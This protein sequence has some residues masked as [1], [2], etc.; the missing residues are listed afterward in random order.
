MVSGTGGI[1]ERLAALEGGAFAR[2]EEDN[3]S[4][5]KIARVEVVVFAVGEL[6]APGAIHIHLEDMVESVLGNM[7]LVRLVLL[8]G[9]FGMECAGGEQ[10]PPAVEGE[11]RFHEAADR[12]VAREAA[13]AGFT[14]LEAFEQTHTAA[15]P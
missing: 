8:V 6:T 10:E 12:H 1:R 7:R 14:G 9:K 11:V 2:G 13:H 4:A 5:R 3:T 15:G